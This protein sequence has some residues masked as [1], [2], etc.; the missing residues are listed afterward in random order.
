MPVVSGTK[1]SV[2]VSPVEI[3]GVAASHTTWSTILPVAMTVYGSS[4]METTAKS[5][6]TARN[7]AVCVPER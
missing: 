1:V 3:D 2:A 6:G 7:L 4:T 5:W